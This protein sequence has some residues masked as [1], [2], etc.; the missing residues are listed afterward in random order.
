[1]AASIEVLHMDIFAAPLPEAHMV[2]AIQDAIVLAKQK[3]ST[4][5]LQAGSSN[6]TV[7]ATDNWRDLVAVYYR[8]R[9]GQ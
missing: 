7:T 6:L 4:V 2:D 8:S 3:Q 5:F 9:V 1:M